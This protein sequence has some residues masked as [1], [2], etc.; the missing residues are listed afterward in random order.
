MDEVL[1]VRGL[2]TQFFT[3]AGTVL[4]VS[5]VSF[6][7][8]RGEMLGIVGESGCGK[9]VTAMSLMRIIPSPP[10]RIV[11]GSAVLRNTTARWI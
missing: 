3:R 8:G 4:A 1:Q 11:A 6:D 9:S 5:D 10:G 7:V 2:T